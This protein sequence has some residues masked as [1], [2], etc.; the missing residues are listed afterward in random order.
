MT[1]IQ[2]IINSNH[3]NT[4]N[5]YKSKAKQEPQSC[6]FNCINNLSC[7]GFNL[8]EFVETQLTFLN[9]KFLRDD[10]KEFKDR[11]NELT[12]SSS[13][14][15]LS[16][17]ESSKI[18]TRLFYNNLMVKT[19]MNAS[20]GFSECVAFLESFENQVFDQCLKT[21]D[22]NQTLKSSDSSLCPCVCK[23]TKVCTVVYLIYLKSI[24]NK[25]EPTLADLLYTMSLSHPDPLHGQLTEPSEKEEHFMQEILK[26]DSNSNKE[27]DNLN[28]DLSQL[29]FEGSK[30]LSSAPEHS[31]TSIIQDDFLNSNHIPVWMP[32]NIHELYFVYRSIEKKSQDPHIKNKTEEIRKIL[33]NKNKNCKIY[34]HKKRKLSHNDNYTHGFNIRDYEKGKYK[35]RLNENVCKD[36]YNAV[37]ENILDSLL[38]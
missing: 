8:L 14:I 26:L 22:S 6:I 30:R 2:D 15:F 28:D 21:L 27:L 25:E 11:I 16:P 23:Y 35:I 17:T 31:I 37:V 36:P 1:N 4:K 20:I 38:Q 5:S 18:S 13:E 32:D 29:T 7:K 12:S 10:L 34:D 24:C 19:L 9:I 33:K 3:C